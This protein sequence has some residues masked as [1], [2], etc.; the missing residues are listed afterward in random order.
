MLGRRLHDPDGIEGPA[1]SVDGLGH[2]DVETVLT[3]DKSLERVEALHGATGKAMAG[4]EMHIGRTEGPDCTRPFA[5]I[6]GAAEGAIAQ[7]GRVEGTYLHGLFA[8]DPFRAAYLSALGASSGGSNYLASVESTLDAL[9]DH[10]E[11]HVD[12]D[13]MLKIAGR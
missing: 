11:R 4:Y 2:L 13:L 8:S 3:P 12:L 6:A 5:S 9:A 7:D 10:L 1:G